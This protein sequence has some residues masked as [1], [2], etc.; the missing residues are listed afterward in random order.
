V[1]AA[2]RRSRHTSLLAQGRERNSI[3]LDASTGRPR[4]DDRLRDLTPASV[5]RR[6]GDELDGIW[7]ADDRLVLLTNVS[8]TVGRTMERVS[9]RHQRIASGPVEVSLVKSI[10]ITPITER[11]LQRAIHRSL[12]MVKQSP[13]G[14]GCR[15]HG[16]RYTLTPTLDELNVTP[17]ASAG[18]A[19]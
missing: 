10:A 16:W 7:N 2:S 13:A 19:L 4:I 14:V 8:S 11:A 3:V 15:L 12:Q 1:R 17:P 9:P 18:L 6:M 5:S